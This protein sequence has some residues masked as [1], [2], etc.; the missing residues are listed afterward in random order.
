MEYESTINLIKSGDV[1]L[2]YLA[3]ETLFLDRTLNLL[4]NKKIDCLAIDEA[5]CIS[6]WGHDFRSEYRKLI[7][8]K[9]E[10]TDAVQLLSLLQP[11]N[12]FVMTLKNSL[13][14]VSQM[15][16]FLVLTGKIYF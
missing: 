4:K 5:H 9:K 10:L 16:L 2:L 13:V 6:D 12:M 8:I 7:S 14:L 3:P 11:Q 15:S 1:K